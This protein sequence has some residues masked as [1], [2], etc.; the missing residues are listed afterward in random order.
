MKQYQARVRLLVAHSPNN[1]EDDSV[2]MLNKTCRPF[3]ST[4]NAEY[5]AA[6]LAYNLY[7][8]PQY[9]EQLGNT[10]RNN[11]CTQFDLERNPFSLNKKKPKKIAGNQS[12]NISSEP[13]VQVTQTS[14]LEWP[15]QCF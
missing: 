4:Y 3:V 8:E 12:D 5:I 9:F 14:Y 7:Q 2:K 1:L 6:S 10:H 13:E 11:I 15:A